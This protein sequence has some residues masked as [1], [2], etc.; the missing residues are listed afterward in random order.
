ME[1]QKQNRL[2][3]MHELQSVSSNAADSSRRRADGDLVVYRSSR[4]PPHVAAKAIA[5][6][7]SLRSL[8]L[9]CQPNAAFAFE[10]PAER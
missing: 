3:F 4:Q 1:H 5:P 9:K 7:G 8:R 10:M 2:R 6:F